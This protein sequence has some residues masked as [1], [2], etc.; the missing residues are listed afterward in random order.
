MVNEVQIKKLYE[1]AQ[2][3]Y[4]GSAGAAGYDLYAYLIDSPSSSLVIP[5]HQTMKVSTGLAMAIPEGYEG[6]IRPRSGLATKRGLRPANTPGT[7]DSDYRGPVIV[8]LHN[9]T[10]ET[11]TIEHGERIAQICFRKVPAMN[12]VEVDNLDETN[13]GSGGFGS[14]GIK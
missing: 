7:I 9:D 1:D 12:L 13:R 10:N 11:Q 5:P 14:T 8:A 4:L 6:Q 3:P 2:L